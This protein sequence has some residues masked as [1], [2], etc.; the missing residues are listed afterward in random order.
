[1]ALK[2]PFLELKQFGLEAVSLE[3]QYLHRTPLISI[4]VPSHPIPTPCTGAPPSQKSSTFSVSAI[5]RA[6]V[7]IGSP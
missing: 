1:M 7:G 4:P 3:L 2:Q 5:H 6:S